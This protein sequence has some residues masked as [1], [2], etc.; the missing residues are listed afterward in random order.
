LLAQQACTAPPG[1]ASCLQRMPSRKQQQQGKQKK[2]A[3]RPLHELIGEAVASN[4]FFCSFEFSAARDP[5]PE[6]LHRRI[7]RMS[8][9][10][11]LWV[12]VTW[13]FGGKSIHHPF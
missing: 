8:A 5:D 6:D 10:G 13:G 7:S 9:L 4:K 2:R 11:P 12:D 1:S 3:P